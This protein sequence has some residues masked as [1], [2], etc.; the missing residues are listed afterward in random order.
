M[1]NQFSTTDQF[2]ALGGVL[3]V[4]LDDLFASTSAKH[5][6]RAVHFLNRYHVNL[7]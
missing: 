6:S 1:I 4:R 7:G 5:P 2:N 3:H